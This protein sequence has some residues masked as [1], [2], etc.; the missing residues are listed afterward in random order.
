L[1]GRLGYNIDMEVKLSSQQP[2]SPDHSGRQGRET[3]MEELINAMSDEDLVALK[4]KYASNESITKLIDGILQTRQVETAKAKVKSD[5]EAKVLKLAK[6]PTPPEGVHNLYLRW[7]EVDEPTGEPEEVEV[8]GVKVMRQ[9]TTK[10]WK[11]VVEVN[12]G[13]QVT[14]TSTTAKVAKRSISV[15]KRE[16]NNLVPVGN[17][18]NATKACEHLKL[19]VGGDS[20]IRVL[21]RDG[22]I[23]DQ[24]AGDDTIV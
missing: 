22:Y 11:W 16:G 20:A 4:A 18:T 10:V 24:Y 15:S 2:I 6:L 21:Q 9:P 19:I 23:I 8:D 5:F 13:F 7:A 17:F 14:R 1:S 3:K 12:K